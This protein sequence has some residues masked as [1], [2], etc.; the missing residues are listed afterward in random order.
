MQCKLCQVELTLEKLYDHNARVL[1]SHFTSV[2]EV[3]LTADSW[4]ALTTESYVTVTCRYFSNWKIIRDQQ[5]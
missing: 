4:T 5:R 3:F 1:H 2:E